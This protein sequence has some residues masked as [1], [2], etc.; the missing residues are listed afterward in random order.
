MYIKKLVTLPETNISPVKI[1]GWKNNPFLLGQMAYFQ[2][3]AFAR[4]FR[5]GKD[6]F[7]W[8]EALR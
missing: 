3:R 5:D 6:S 1:N 4:S 7:K 2:G 8:G